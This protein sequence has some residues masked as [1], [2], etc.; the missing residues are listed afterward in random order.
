VDGAGGIDN[1]GITPTRR[2]IPLWVLLV[3]GNLVILVAGIAIDWYSFERHPVYLALNIAG[4]AA[5]FAVGLLV[6]RV[7]QRLV[8]G[9]CLLIA[10]FLWLIK[11]ISSWEV[12]PLPFIG[13]NSYTAF[14]IVAGIGFVYWAANGR[15]RPFEKV[16]IGGLCGLAVE[17]AFLFTS[18][19]PE[20]VG[21]PSSVWWPSMWANEERFDLVLDA[22]VAYD[23]LIGASFAAIIV[24]R[25][26][27]ARDIDRAI[28]VPIGLSAA[29]LA[30]FA[31]LGQ[32]AGNVF[33]T[34]P[35][36]GFHFAVST[37][38]FVLPAGVLIGLSVR[39]RQ[40]VRLAGSLNRSF[41]RQVPT[42]DYV[43]TVLREELGDP[44]LEIQYWSPDAQAYLIPEAGNNRSGSNCVSRTVDG[45]NGQPLA[46][47]LVDEALEKHGHLIDTAVDASRVALE[48]ARLNAVVH[49]Q[50]DEVR[51]SRQRITQAALEERRRIERDLHDGVQQRLLALN[52]QLGGLKDRANAEV[53]DDIDRLGSELR[54]T[55]GSLRSLAQ[56]IHPTELRQFGLKVALEQV[57]E[58][59]PLDVALDVEP[60]RLDAAI[61]STLYFAI[62]EALTNVVKHAK[63]TNADVRVE[64]QGSKI[65]ATVSD[66][67]C[68]LN[69]SVPRRGLVGLDDRAR[70]LGG[71]LEIT[72]NEPTGTTLKLSIPWQ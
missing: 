42:L 8:L 19:R 5:L 15:L 9:Y 64:S 37:T 26:I 34:T 52:A 53:I 6:V 70:A 23:V 60:A 38:V 61:E 14:Y 30:I 27:T 28:M 63:A 35:V 4:S 22:V 12:G 45:P 7:F 50:L 25:V 68:G 24:Y 41:S 56:G 16:F 51:A 40:H 33:N 57:I 59:L 3:A 10:S 32:A 36:T 13:T 18:T 62:C 58:G 48:N 2:P 54:S 17:N 47:L 31:A 65:V 43:R 11:R 55:L 44:S 20:W 29:L 72:P 69:V 71:T 1:A 46:K 66:N 39:L 21:F 49:S 67:G